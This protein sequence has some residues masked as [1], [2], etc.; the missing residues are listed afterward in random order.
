[1]LSHKAALK[2]ILVDDNRARSAVL[3]TALFNAGHEV[4][5]RLGKSDELRNSQELIHADVIVLNISEPKEDMLAHL[6]DINQNMPKPIV[7]FAEKSEDSSMANRAVQSGVSAFIVDGLEEKR[8]QAIVDVAIARF[9]EFQAMKQEL[10]SLQ[11]KLEERKIVEKAK[12][13]L[14]QHKRLT[15]EA[16][17]T[18][19]RTMAMNKNI[20]IGEA[21][22]HIVSVLE[23]FE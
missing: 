16:A 17:Y 10:L 11:G 7:L 21:A 2:V 14:I 5:C 15:E 6:K 20:K 8:V 13:L 9:A 3:R 19:I 12:G 4:L 23:L 22:H 1:M 18:S